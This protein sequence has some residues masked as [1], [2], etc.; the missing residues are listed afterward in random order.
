MHRVTN[1]WVAANILI[2]GVS[3]IALAW[4]SNI[5]IA[6]V[7][8]VPLGFGGAAMIA[9]ANSIT[10]E[11]APPDMR[12]R[13]LALTA[14]AFLGSTPIGGPITGWIADHI[15]AS[16]SLG[17]GGIIAVVTSLYML[18]RLKRSVS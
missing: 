5:W 3:N 10:Q 17:Y 12:G 14:V 6:F 7:A 15:S 16:W 4:S 1:G 13:L 11:V 18:A 8:A 2:L 9:G